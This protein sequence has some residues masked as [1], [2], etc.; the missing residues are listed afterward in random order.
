MAKKAKEN[1]A[2]KHPYLFLKYGIV[3]VITRSGLAHAASFDDEDS[4]CPS[5]REALVC[6]SKYFECNIDDVKHDAVLL[7]EKIY[8]YTRDH[9]CGSIVIVENE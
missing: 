1:P 4:E 6:M 9:D 8:K 7:Y 2:S 5:V 3:V